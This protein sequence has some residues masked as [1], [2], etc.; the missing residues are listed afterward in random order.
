MHYTKVR[1]GDPETDSHVCENMWKITEIAL[2]IPNLHPTQIFLGGLRTN[3]KTTVEEN[4]GRCLYD[5]WE[6]TISQI[7]SVKSE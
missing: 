2:Q 6:R 3:G 4:R 1:R 5:F 7:N